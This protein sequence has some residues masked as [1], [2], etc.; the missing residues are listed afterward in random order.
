MPSGS[1]DGGTSGGRYFGSIHG[2]P[3]FSFSVGDEEDR[4]MPTGVRG[5]V[6]RDPAES[7]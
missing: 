2:P 3:V 5:V 6:F 7:E 1:V 4:R